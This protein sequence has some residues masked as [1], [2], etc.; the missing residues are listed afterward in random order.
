MKRVLFFDIL[1]LMLIGGCSA[2]LTDTGMQVGKAA[3]EIGTITGNPSMV[4]FGM[5][6]F[7]ISDFLATVFIRK[8]KKNG[9][10]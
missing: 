6:L 2:S 7:L 10:S 5:T 9:K 1:L 3:Q 8:V 4:T